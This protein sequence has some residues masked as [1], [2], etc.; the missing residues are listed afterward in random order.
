MCFSSKNTSIKIKILTF[1]LP[2]FY[3]K[4]LC[5][6]RKTTYSPQV[7]SKKVEYSLKLFL[8]KIVSKKQTITKNALNC[9]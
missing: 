1:F 2:Y 8:N 3:S 7:I 4:K 6:Y 5:F 9:T